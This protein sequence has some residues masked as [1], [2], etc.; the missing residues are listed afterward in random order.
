MP[1]YGLKGNWF[2]IFCSLLQRLDKWG[3]DIAID[4][5]FVCNHVK[6]TDSRAHYECSSRHNK[7]VAHCRTMLSH[8][9]KAA[10][11][12]NLLAYTCS[13]H[14][15]GAESI[16][17]NVWVFKQNKRFKTW[18]AFIF[19]LSCHFWRF[20]IWMFSSFI[21]HISCNECN[22]CTTDCMQRAQHIC[23]N[24]VKSSETLHC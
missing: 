7:D 3:W 4:V 5:R 11:G 13:A 6:E 24:S 1:I 8:F 14:R 15:I 21:P 22:K 2:L 23:L 12:V 9:F 20:P 19:K 17:Q 10:I 16:W 18:H